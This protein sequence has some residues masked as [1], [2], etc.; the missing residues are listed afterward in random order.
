MEQLLCTHYEKNSGQ[1]LKKVPSVDEGRRSHNSLRL[2][3]F[4][5]TNLTVIQ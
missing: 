4:F 1:N 5:R 3:T 2:Q